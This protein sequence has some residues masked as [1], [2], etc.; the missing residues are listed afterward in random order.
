MF[1]LAE[2]RV[3]AGKYT[4]E[5]PLARGGMGVIW[6]VRHAPL[7]AVMAA[8]FMV[9]SWTSSS[10]AS[11]RFK[12][13]A[14]AAA[15]VSSAHVVRVH[16]YGIEEDTPFLIME[17]LE[18]ED[19]G[20]RLRR[21]DRLSPAT[22]AD[23]LGQAARGLRRAHDAGIVH[24][25][26]K[27]GN[28]FLARN[29]EDDDVVKLLDFGIAKTMHGAAGM[30][31][32]KSD[33]FL[34]SIHYMSPEQVRSPARVDPRADLW[35]LAA[36]AYRALTGKHPFEGDDIYAVILSICHDS[37]PPPSR[38]VPALPRAIDQFFERAFAKAPGARFQTASELAAAF[39]E[40]VGR[41]AVAEPARPRAV[42]A[43]R[44][45]APSDAPMAMET[46]AIEPVTADSAPL[47]SPALNSNGHV[48]SLAS[49]GPSGNS[50]GT[51]RPAHRG[52]ARKV[53]KAVM[54]YASS[55]PGPSGERH[56]RSQL[57]LGAAFVLASGGIAF[58]LGTRM[59]TPRPAPSVRALLSASTAEGADMPSVAPTEPSG[60]ATALP[61]HPSEA[62][63]ASSPPSPRESI[64]SNGVRANPQAPVLHR[65]TPPIKPSTKA[66]TPA[67][68]LD[69]SA[70]PGERPWRPPPTP[71]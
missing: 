11:A 21:V 42:G 56:S 14:W 7:D 37:H 12:R 45:T 25:D 13:E 33:H 23:I 10:Q 35:A 36:L 66:S 51:P 68:T 40:A 69:P 62:L 15:Q 6:V 26:L 63:S 57:A 22:V 65:A 20:A 29:D 39:T 9:A 27:P 48:R 70:L 49:L 47:F 24:R 32:T 30:E 50:S 1:Q 31:A 67:P 38:H 53:V 41:R 4:L 2:G 43:P 19:L 44:A 16:D 5:R 54:G 59:V 58:G 61:S 52:L 46:A 28:V 18:G 71:L 8:K 3:L 64:V 34:G 17:L 60:A 55:G